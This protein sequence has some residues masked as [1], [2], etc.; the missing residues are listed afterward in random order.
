MLSIRQRQLP[1]KGAFTTVHLFQI[2]HGL[3]LFKLIKVTTLPPYTS[4]AIQST[5][6]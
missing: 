3:D 6:R 2:S 4:P 5:V 1:Q